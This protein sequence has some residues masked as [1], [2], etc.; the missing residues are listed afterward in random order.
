MENVEKYKGGAIYSAGD[1][2]T[3]I[4]FSE[5]CTLAD[6]I[7]QEGGALYLSQS[8]ECFIAHGA[9]MEEG[10]MYLSFHPSILVS[11]HSTIL[12][13]LQIQLFISTEIK[14]GKVVGYILDLI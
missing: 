8:V 2:K 10:F 1:S 12:I 14:Q 3:L 13:R 4:R 7:A 11:D 9:P 5:V 6:N